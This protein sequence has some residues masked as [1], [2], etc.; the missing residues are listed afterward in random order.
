MATAPGSRRTTPLLAVSRT[1]ATPVDVT[2]QLPERLS[3]SRAKDFTQ[4]PRLFFY[5]TILKLSTPNTEAT[6]KGT[7]AHYAFEH[8][9]DHPRTERTP[10]NAVPYVRV[11]W[12]E[13]RGTDNYKE[14]VALGDAANEAMVVEAERMVRAWFDMES[15]TKWDPEGREQWV[16]G[17]VGP[18]TMHG[19]IDRLDK[20]VVDGETRWY[21]AD[22]KTG[23]IPKDRYLAEN[24]FAMNIYSVLLQEE[25][26]ITAYELRLVYVKNGSRDDIRRQRVTPESLRRTRDKMAG[27]GKQLQAAA[28]SGDF[29]TKTGP[30]CNWCDFQSFCPAFHPELDGLDIEEVRARHAG[31]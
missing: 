15:P 11:H 24:F 10:E 26:D 5:K 21:V 2:D 18:V 9:F 6:T 4:C 13:L 1:T 20:V 7:L 12:D 27:I 8:I 3:P 29:P 19:V 28:K 30:L 23:A 14:I 25:L 17:A 22:Y 31:E 16:R